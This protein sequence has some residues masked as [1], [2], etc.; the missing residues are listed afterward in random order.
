MKIIAIIIRRRT[1]IIII[2]QVTYKAKK[3]RSHTNDVSCLPVIYVL[4][5][6]VDEW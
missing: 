5:S 2:Q 4:G 3:T 1:I 6:F